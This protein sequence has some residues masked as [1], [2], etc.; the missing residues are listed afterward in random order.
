M[1]RIL[2]CKLYKASPRK[3]KILA[4]MQNPKNQGLLVQLGEYLDKQYQTDALLNPGG[5]QEEQE[6]DAPEGEKKMRESET[7]G[8]GGGGGHIAGLGEGMELM[9]APESEEDLDALMNEEG[10]GEDLGGDEAAPAEEEPVAEATKIKG[11]PV[12]ACKE[13][14]SSELDSIKSSLNLVE[15]TQGVVRAAIKNNELWLYYDD[16]KNL[17][18]IMEFVIEALPQM[19]ITWAEFNRL[20]RSDNAIVFE[21]ILQSTTQPEPSEDE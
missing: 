11:K 10:G 13:V 1:Y 16:D 20:A 21:M 6:S 14:T 17:N 8:G 7:S 18:N 12:K 19:G 4:S 2:N 15:E 9:D 5:Q 3:D